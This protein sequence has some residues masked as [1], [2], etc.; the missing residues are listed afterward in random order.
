MPMGLC[1]SPATHQQHVT[2]ALRDLIGHICHIY[3][4]DIII[5]SQSVEEHEHNVA[6][7]LEVL[8]NAHLYCSSKKSSLF[9]IEINFLGHTISQHGIEAD[10]SE[11]EWI[12][13]WP[14]PKMAKDVCQ[15]L[16]LVRYI[17]TFLPALAE[18]T[19]V[20][21]PLTCKECNRLFPPW[22]SEHHHAFKSIKALVVSCDCLTTIDHQNPGNNQI[23]I[24]C[25]TSQKGTGAV[26]SFRPTWES[27]WPVAFESQ[28]LHGAELHY[29]IHEQEMLAIIHALKKWHVN[30]LGSHFTIHT[31]HQT[32]QNFEIQ[33]ELSK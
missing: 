20:L 9:N 26:L 4:N 19:I 27:A 11:V 15:F 25:D 7:V 2:L 12:L 14:T 17:S 23:F 22:M 3:L 31:D 33:K 16:S 8:Q 29:L 21:T 28:Q 18:H 13:N 30:L 6:L 32:L 24:T 10:R 5:W 1:N